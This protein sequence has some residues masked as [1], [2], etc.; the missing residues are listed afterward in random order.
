MTAKEWVDKS[1]NNGPVLT[2]L[3][4]A[5]RAGQEAMREKAAHVANEWVVACDH[6]GE[7]Q[8]AIEALPV[9]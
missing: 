2:M 7:I 3:E 4:S 1:Q 8:R 5:H 9:E 6:A